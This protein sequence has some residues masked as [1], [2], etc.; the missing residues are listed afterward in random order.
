[1]AG[2]GGPI[3]AVLDAST[4]TSALAWLEGEGAETR[5]VALEIVALDT[6]VPVAIRLEKLQG[7][8]VLLEQLRTTCEAEWVRWPERATVAS[9][10]STPSRTNPDCPRLVERVFLRRGETLG[11]LGAYA[12][13]GIQRPSPE[14]R[15]EFRAAFSLGPVGYLLPTKPTGGGWASCA[16]TNFG[17]TTTAPSW[18]GRARPFSGA[19]SWRTTS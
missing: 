9:L 11:F 2:A 19:I 3:V 5:V 1:M 16:G 8:T 15:R 4:Q 13:A 6:G 7:Q 17:R 14:L 12:I 18:R 10:A